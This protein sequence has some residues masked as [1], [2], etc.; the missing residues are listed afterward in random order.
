M[1]QERNWKNIRKFKREKLDRK[2]KILQA[3]IEIK[4]FQILPVEN[5][6]TIVKQGIVEIKQ[7]IE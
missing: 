2:Q 4:A 1:Y 3:I 6:K 5:E 7:L